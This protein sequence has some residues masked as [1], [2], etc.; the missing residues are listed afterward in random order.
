MSLAL[1]L[2]SVLACGGVQ[3]DDKP[4]DSGL[5]AGADTDTDADADT[6]V[7]TDTDTDTDGFTDV[8]PAVDWFVT[9]TSEA[10]LELSGRAPDD[11]YGVVAAAGDV[12]GDGLADFAFARSGDEPG[13]TGETW[14]DLVYGSAHFDAPVVA[15]FAFG[16]GD[17]PRA[18]SGVGD[19]TGD[20][21]D[22]FVVCASGA[23]LFGD[24]AGVAW[25]LPG[26]ERWRG[27]T[28]VESVAAARV[29]GT[30]GQQVCAA[31]VPALDLT[32]NGVDDLLLGGRNAPGGD[33]S[34]GVWLLEG[35]LS[36]DL[37]TSS[38]AVS[39]AGHGDGAYAGSALALGDLS[40]DGVPD[41]AV[42]ALGAGPA[43]NAGVIDIVLGPLGSGSLQDADYS[44]TGVDAA[45]GVGARDTI[46]IGD[47]DGDGRVDLI[48]SAPGD[49]ENELLVNHGTIYVVYGDDLIDAPATSLARTRFFGLRPDQYAGTSVAVADLDNDGDVEVLFGAPDEVGITSG[50]LYLFDDPGEG[51]YS[52]GEADGLVVGTGFADRLG[53]SIAVVGDV[54]GDRDK[55]LVVGA[56]DADTIGPDVGVAYLLL[57]EV[58]P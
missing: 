24:D 56:P 36:G 4:R 45:D 38:A 16:E 12:D 7:D 53:T 43:S 8:P 2:V 26:G 18:M 32:G 22:D 19:V 15:T 37:D 42:G 55:D 28:S 39:L 34:G 51:R 48:F 50:A 54:D 14:V 31:V 5:T 41:L 9:A 27:D 58:A 13:A 17:A 46:G 30:P 11:R 40:G 52:A 3:R 35:P 1:L 29:H 44:I 23:S 21:S 49:E 20:G 57:S 47:L 25:V 10:A 33:T 6:D